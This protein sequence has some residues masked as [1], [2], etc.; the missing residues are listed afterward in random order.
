MDSIN[1]FK[2]NLKL[3]SKRVFFPK[4]LKKTLIFQVQK[5]IF[6]SLLSFAA[7]HGKHGAG[8]GSS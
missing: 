5:L 4:A 3:Y 8:S 6:G 2:S 1:I 7:S